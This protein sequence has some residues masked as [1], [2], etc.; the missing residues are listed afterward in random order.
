MVKP[1]LTKLFSINPS[2]IPDSVLDKYMKLVEV[3]GKK[4]GVLTL[5][6]I[7]EMTK[8]VD[9]ILRQL[10]E[11]QSMAISLKDRFDNSEKITDDDGK[12]SY[13]ATLK[14]MLDEGQITDREFEVMKKYK[15]EIMPKTDGS[16][17]ES[18]AEAEVARQANLDELS[19]KD[20]VNANE[21]PSR[22]E[23]NLANRLRK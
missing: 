15:A 16:V 19:K 18:K 12:V 22:E 23:R 6:E 20:I 13:A 4:E 2:M 3:F 10:D 21:L 11:E 9:A 17:T 7:S 8:D 5:P 1:Q 14:S